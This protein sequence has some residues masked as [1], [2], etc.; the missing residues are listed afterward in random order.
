LPIA[1]QIKSI[2]LIEAFADRL[3]ESTLLIALSGA[4]VDLMIIGINLSLTTTK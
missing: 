2:F 1:K 3:I 4:I